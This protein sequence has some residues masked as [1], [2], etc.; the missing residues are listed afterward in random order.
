MSRDT[1]VEELVKQSGSEPPRL[2]LASSRFSS[3]AC[4]QGSSGQLHP[5]AGMPRG[6]NSFVAVHEAKRLA[7]HAYMS[8]SCFLDPAPEM[9][10]RRAR[11]LR[12]PCRA[13]PC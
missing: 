7:G 5:M 6:T 8:F 2:M 13:Q 9:Q 12:Q 11:G 1:K 3:D 10:G 4:G